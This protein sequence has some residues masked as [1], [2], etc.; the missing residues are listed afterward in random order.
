MHARVCVCV[1]VWTR[2]PGAVEPTLALLHINLL[3]TNKLMS[4]EPS[5]HYVVPTHFSFCI[6]SQHQVCGDVALAFSAS[7]CETQD[8]CLNDLPGSGDEQETVKWAAVVHNL[9]R[10]NLN[11]V[12]IWSDLHN[13]TMWANTA[14]Q[15]GLNV[16]SLKVYS[17]C[18][19]ASWALIL[20]VL[21]FAEGT[22]V[23]SESVLLWLQRYCVLFF[24]SGWE[25]LSTDRG[26]CWV[27]GLRT[28]L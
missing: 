12:F 4:D 15:S 24:R 23:I 9:A 5:S 2:S 7:P 28:Y 25:N 14:V 26:V 11:E 16:I 20:C 18:A 21:G 1:C 8:C 6:K 17:H 22:D 13:I 19:F 10:C 3:F 27:Q